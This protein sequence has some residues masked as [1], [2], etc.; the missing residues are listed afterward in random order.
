MIACLDVDLD[1]IRKVLNRLAF[2]A[3][4][5]Q[6]DL[7]GT[8]DISEKDLVHGLLEITKQNINPR[9]MIDFLQNRAGIL[10]ERGVGVQTFP[11]RTFQ[12]YL[13]ACYLT[14]T[15]YPDTVAQL[16][17][18]DL[19]RWREVLLLAAAKA[20]TGTDLPVWALAVELCLPDASSHVDQVSL[21]GAYLAAQALLESANLETI[22][23]RN[24]QTLNGI[25]D[26]L[27]N[28]MQGSA[29]PAIERAKAGDYLARLGDPR[30]SVTHIEHMEFCFVP[31]G[32]FF[33]GQ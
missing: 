11:H 12:E 19:N 2:E 25:K 29:M 17:K 24:Q 13:A 6:P 21:T 16:A 4:K 30:K 1:K 28:I 8:A 22:K 31:T 18:T 33:N 9:Q 32:P 27:I 15:D 5:N 10:I 3:H 7:K 26:S 14:D 23:P 20:G